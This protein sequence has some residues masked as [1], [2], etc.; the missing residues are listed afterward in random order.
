MRYTARARWIALAA[1]LLCASA[2]AQAPLLSQVHTVA[3]ADRAV[4]VEHS[5]AITTAGTYQVTLTDLGAAQSVP[6]PAPLTAVKLAVT[7]GSTVV[8]MLAAAGSTTFAATAGTYA[9]HVIGQ[10]GATPGSGPIGV[11]VTNIGTSSVVASFSDTLA[12]A[13]SPLPSSEAAVDDT[14]TVTATDTYTVSLGDLQL[15]S[16]LGTLIL[17]IAQPGGSILATLP[18]PGST[19]VQ[20]APG[21]YSLFAIAQAGSNAAGGLFGVTVTGT[22]AG[23]IYAK[24][25]PL[26][27]VQL[28]GS[29]TLAAGNYTLTATDLVLPGALAQLGAVIALGGQSIAAVGAAGQQGFVVAATASYPV[30]ALATPGA[31][32][33][34]SYALAVQSTAAGAPAALSVARA[35]STAGGA[36]SAY[37][38][39]TTVT[40]PGTYALDLTDFAFP[41]QLTS[42]QAAAVQNGAVLGAALTAA[43]TKDVTPAVGPVSLIVFAQAATGG[44]L[45]GI[46]LTS[47][48][49]NAM[50]LL[51]TTQGV[52]QLFSQQQVSITTA[53]SYSVTVTDLQWPAGL[54]NL[55]VIVTQGTNQVGSIFGGGTFAFMATPGNY[56]INFIAQPGGTDHAGTYAMSVAPSPAPPTVNLTSDAPSVASGGTVHLVWSSQNATSCTAS[57]GW[58]GSQALSG[59]ATTSAIT[60]VTT[61]TLACSGPGGSTSQ[62]VTVTI[63]APTKGGGGGG[64]LDVVSLALLLFALAWMRRA[65][66]SSDPSQRAMRCH[67]NR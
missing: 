19:Q 6:G 30:F 48:A 43:G 57:G 56:F 23:T 32:G 17:A 63:A 21:T 64:G 40:A 54:S 36:V 16:S 59:T 13:A 29:P 26:G 50:P 4:P 42:L 60:A 58:T 3:A 41:A 28:L 25:V 34:G 44:G 7:S 31:G 15:P 55:A 61:F 51:T 1:S 52:G 39:D 22:S 8:A 14:L 11:Q 47:T 2:H 9:I 27:G 49:A 20:L 33:T 5:V 18:G 10:P 45:F 35:V 65:A 38:F 24:T 66:R 62:S 37:S 67:T 53:G 46:D 12:L